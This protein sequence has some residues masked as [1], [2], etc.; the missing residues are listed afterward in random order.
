MQCRFCGTVLQTGAEACPSCGTPVTAAAPS[1]FFSYGSSFDTVPYT[2]YAPSV[3]TSSVSSSQPSPPHLQYAYTVGQ[4][5]RPYRVGLLT[6]LLVPLLALPTG[7]IQ[8]HT[9]ATYQTYQQGL[10]TIISGTTDYH[11]SK[12]GSYYTPDFQYTVST[13]DGQQVDASGYDAPDQQHYDTQGEAQA[14]VDSY[15]VGQP[16]TCWYNPADPTH[17]VLVFRG[18]DTNNLITDYILTSLEFFSGFA[19]L[20]YLLY[21]I[22]YRQLCLMRRGVLTE[23]KVVEHFERRS[24]YGTKT[25]SRIFFAPVDD[26]SLSYKVETQGEYVVGSQQPVCYD[27]LNPK[28]ARYGDRPSGGSATT[29]LI[30]FIVGV[31]IGAAVLYGIWYGV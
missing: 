7:L 22:F 15:N 28:N 23:G 8:F 6:F 21:Y 2:P 20:W 31:L 27:P 14:V 17:A 11:S 16:Y 9:Y 19:F 30:G 24:R 13:K 4:A 25:Y 29:A 10:C 18:Y 12:S 3:E 26:P 1:D 5:R